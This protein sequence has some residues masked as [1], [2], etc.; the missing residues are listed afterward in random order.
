MDFSQI[1]TLKKNDKSFNK[2]RIALI[3]IIVILSGFLFLLVMHHMI[4]VFPRNDF[5]AN[6]YFI[7]R[8]YQTRSIIFDGTSIVNPL[9]TIICI[10]LARGLSIDFKFVELAVMTVDYMMIAFLVTRYLFLEHKDFNS[11]WMPVVVLSIMLYAPIFLNPAVDLR[12][13][14]GYIPPTSYHNPTIWLAKL[15]GFCS[16][17]LFIHY[18]QQPKI[19]VKIYILTMLVSAAS[20]LSKPN[21]SMCFLPAAGLLIVYLFLKKQPLNLK[22]VIIGFFLPLVG[23]LLWQYYINYIVAPYASLSIAPFVV[24]NELSQHEN[25]LVDLILGALFPLTV[26]ALYFKEVIHNKWLVYA[27]GQFAIGLGFFYIFT[28]TGKH[29]FDGNFIWG[30]ETALFILIILSAGFWLGKFKQPSKKWMEYIPLVVMIAHGVYGL[31]YWYYSLT[32][33]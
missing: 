18:L 6:A 4:F 19:P 20:I 23:I 11:W 10:L 33:V 3:A 14:Y 16:V 30:P 12:Y 21:F 17:I 28:E 29:Q 22:F 5:K 24:A 31:V 2:K 27:W 13:P 15:F 7:Q 32:V 9:Y 26:L 1:T 25:L 8:I